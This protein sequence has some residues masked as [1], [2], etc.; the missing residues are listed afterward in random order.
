MRT[1]L[2]FHKF[3]HRIANQP[4]IITKRKFHTE[5]LARLA[6]HTGESAGGHRVELRMK[7]L[8]EFSPNSRSNKR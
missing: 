8:G 1:H 3:A 7:L 5:M 2:G 6:T 4:L